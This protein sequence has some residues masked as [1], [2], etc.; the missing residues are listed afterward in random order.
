MYVYIHIYLHT[1]VHVYIFMYLSSKV[2]H[3]ITW[4]E[5]V[6]KRTETGSGIGP[7]ECLK[8]Y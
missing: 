8:V 4:G 1:Y 7:G 3:E 5:W 6:N 2:V